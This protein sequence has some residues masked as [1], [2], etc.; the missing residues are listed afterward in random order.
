MEDISL[1]LPVVQLLKSW[2]YKND[3]YQYQR[4]VG[5]VQLLKSWE[6]KNASPYRLV[7]VRVVQLLKSWEYKNLKWNFDVF[8]PIIPKSR[9]NINTTPSNDFAHVKSQVNL[10]LVLDFIFEQM[11]LN[12]QLVGKDIGILSFTFI[13]PLA[14]VAWSIS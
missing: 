5:V 3:T 9:K 4:L 12:Y 8:I 1:V 11:I 10:D 13:L 6:Y 7:S 2:E 14:T